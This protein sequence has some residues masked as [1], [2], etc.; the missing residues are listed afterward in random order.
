M[1]TCGSPARAAPQPPPLS[2]RGAGVSLTAAK[3]K[4]PPGC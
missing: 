2:V 3:Y 4:R 1:P